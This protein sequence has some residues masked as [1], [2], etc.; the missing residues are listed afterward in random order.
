M[1][2]IFSVSCRQSHPLRVSFLA[3][4]SFAYFF[5]SNSD[6]LL[7]SDGKGAASLGGV[8]GRLEVARDSPEIVNFCLLLLDFYLLRGDGN[9][10][11]EWLCD[12]AI[13]EAAA[14]A[15]E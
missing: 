8:Q 5:L 4:F 9:G 1:L 6:N 10:E 11:W 12:V 3:Q 13:Q 14:A 7:C 15:F 2:V